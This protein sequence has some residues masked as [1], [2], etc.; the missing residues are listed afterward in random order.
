MSV[1]IQPGILVPPAPNTIFSGRFTDRWR[2][3]FKIHQARRNLRTSIVSAIKSSCMLK[4]GLNQMTAG[5]AEGLRVS[6]SACIKLPSGEGQRTRDC[7][8]KFNGLF[9]VRIF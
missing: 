8:R 1:L 3:S 9:D 6:W 4:K 2:R 5:K 7:S